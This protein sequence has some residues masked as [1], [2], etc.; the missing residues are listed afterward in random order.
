MAM[1]TRLTQ[2]YV[3]SIKPPDA[4]YWITD[5]GCPKL[6][7]YVGTHRKIWYVGYRDEKN[8]Y[9]NHKLGSAEALTVAQARDMAL[10]FTARLIRGEVLQKKKRPHTMSLDVFL[11]SHYAPWA[12]AERKSGEKT[13]YLL[14][15]A[16][17]QFLDKPIGELSIKTMEKW[18]HEKMA[19]G[20]KAA[21]CN[22][23]L[24]ALKAALNWGV[25]RE[26]L[27]SNPLAR[28]EKL[29]EHDSDVKVRYLTDE[30]RMR[31]MSALDEREKKM[32]SG[33]QSHNR[34]LAERGQALIPELDGEFAD[35][36]KPMILISLY[37][38]MRQGNLF[39]L[40]WGD[41][42]FDTKTL[43]LRAAASKT[44]KNHDLPM[45][46]KVIAA[47]QAWRRQSKKVAADSLVFPSPVSGKMLNNVKKAWL[48]VLR[49]A[50]IENFRWHDMRHDFASQLVMKGIDLNTVRELM[51]HSDL[52]MTL[53]YAHLAPDNKLRAVEIL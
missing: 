45:N 30:E 3:N 19:S 15:S 43:R 8:T 36:L 39:A 52:K 7:L 42:D 5:A 49:D 9:T 14:R 47:L 24:A 20:T 35:H 21:T 51:G 4:P 6:R 1:K 18:R 50:G 29:P 32:R 53:R 25:K 31:L 22:R 11:E 12:T 10:D 28:L 44:G 23:R 40:R 26:Y 37:T 17:R 41:I 33:R 34:W 16:F 38:G 48:A 27:E 46:S 13:L 2:L